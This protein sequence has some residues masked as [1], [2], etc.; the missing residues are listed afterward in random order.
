FAEYD[1]IPGRAALGAFPLHTAP[2]EPRLAQVLTALSALAQPLTL[3]GGK[4]VPGWWAAHDPRGTP[5]RPARGH[6]NLGTAHGIPGVLMLSIMAARAG[7]SGRCQQ[8]CIQH[9]YA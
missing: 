6:A 4:K 2:A 9:Q 8:Y 1:V 3:A 5:T 7:Y